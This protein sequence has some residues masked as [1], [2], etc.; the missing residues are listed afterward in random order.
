MKRFSFLSVVM[1]GALALSFSTTQ[2]AILIDHAP[3]VANGGFET[4]TGLPYN[5]GTDWVNGDGN[6][7][8][9]VYDTAAHT[10][11][12]AGVVSA[13][14]EPTNTTGWTIAEGDKIDLSF[15]LTGNG[16][17]TRTVHWAVGSWDGSA[18]TE[19]A[20]GGGGDFSAAGTYLTPTLGTITVGA[21]DPTI[22][23]F[24]SVQFTRVGLGFPR[25]DDVV[26]SA[27]AV[28]EPA[29]L[30][31]LSLGGLLMLRRRRVA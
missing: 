7:L 13:A 3:A 6:P 17:T 5:T 20:A 24:L 21:G 31:L 12:T 23:D 30:V 19:I 27:T 25:V 1:I 14:S 10:G 18:F 28:P 16:A 11:T 2:A 15:W 22:G 29:S 9:N 26:L 8:T 4:H